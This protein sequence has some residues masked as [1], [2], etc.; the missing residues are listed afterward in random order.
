MTDC[1][2]PLEVLVFADE[3]DSEEAGLGAARARGI[4]VVACRGYFIYRHVR[5]RLI[6]GLLNQAKQKPTQTDIIQINQCV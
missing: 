1:D 5:F 2:G 4:C 3:L 6:E